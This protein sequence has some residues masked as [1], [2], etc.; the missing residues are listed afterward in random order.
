MFQQLPAVRRRFVLRFLAL[1]SLLG[2]LASTSVSAQSATAIIGTVT[3]TTGGALPGVTVTVSGPALQV[4]SVTAVTDAKGEYRVSPLPQGMF[5]VTFELPGFQSVKRDNLQLALGFTATLNQSLGLGTVAETVTVSGE[6]PLVDVKNPATSSDMSA[7]SLEILP[8]NRDGLKAFMGTMPGVRTNLDVGS[9]S[10]SDTVVFTSYGQSGQAWQTLD[11]VMFGAPNSGGANGSHI[12][13]NAMDSTRVQTVGS[14]AEMPRRGVM[15]DAALKSGGNEFHGLEEYY[16]SN[17]IFESDNV[18]SDA[19]LTAVGLTRPPKLHNLWDVGGTLGGKLIKDKLWFF[20]S[21]RRTGFDREIPFAFYNDGTPMLDQRRLPYAALK[22]SYQPNQANKFTGFYHFAK[23]LEFRGGSATADQ[24]TR[25]VYEGP[26]DIYGLGWQL[27]KGNS[28]VAN[29]DGGN[30]MQKAWYFAFASYENI[31]AGHPD[32]AAVHMIPTLDTFTQKKTGDATSDGQW[33]HRYRYPVKGTVSFYRQNLLGGN[34]EFKAG[35]EYINSGYNQNQRG[36]PQGNYA[37]RF[38]QGVPTQIITSNYPVTPLNFDNYE[39]MFLQDSWS[40]SRRLTLSLGVRWSTDE[41]FAPAQC[42]PGNEFVAGACYAA[43][44]LARWTTAM[45]RLHF[46]YDLFGNGKTVLKGG[47]GRFAN[48]RDLSPELTRVAQNNA[49]HIT[50]TWHDLNGDKQYQPG[51][52]NLDPNGQ[53]FQSIAGVTNTIPNPN[54]P[55]PQSDEFSLTLERQLMGNWAVR[56]TGVYARNVNLRRLE[57]IARPP[58]VYTIPITNPDPG[59]DGKVGTADDPGKSITYYEYP[60]SLQGINFATTKDVGVPG[61]QTYSTIELEGTRRISRGWQAAASISATKLN[62]PFADEQAYN[63]NTEIYTANNTW[64]TTAKV[65]GGYTLPFDVVMSTTYERRGGN[66][67]APNARFTGGKTISQLTVNVAPIGTIVLPASNL[68]NVR[69]AKRIR[70]GSGRTLEARFDY[71]NIFNANFVTAE[72]TTEGP[73]Y[74][75]PTA[76]ILPR[77]LQM[78][79][80]FTF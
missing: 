28:F 71:F 10:L 77:I 13:F 27:V 24:T 34:H 41:A 62:V 67:T 60:T 52:V 63:P 70:L 15:L 57:E 73:T 65:S 59:P 18:S 20:G 45:P 5:T 37:L 12:D 64:Q 31:R 76:V 33:L 47:Y 4:P 50:W 75:V 39:A 38:N 30:W 11:G 19:A 21:Y 68:W 1:L 3:D 23:E 22:L 42:S 72:G 80:T 44:S 79:V 54:E 6:S 36:D 29:V 2:L 7:Q 14:S 55:Q 46:A 35:F 78:G 32:T 43:I 25:E 16:G 56:T 49:Q 17:G 9:S 61:Q 51:E 74:L 48:L 66:P 58:S 26:I 8:T 53:D 69:F 40:V